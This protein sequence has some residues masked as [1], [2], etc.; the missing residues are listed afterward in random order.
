[1]QKE[2]LLLES[3]GCISILKKAKQ[4]SLFVNGQLL[5]VNGKDN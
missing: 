2:A 4:L 3:W 5:I 1:M